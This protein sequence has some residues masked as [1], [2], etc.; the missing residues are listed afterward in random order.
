MRYDLALV[1]QLCREIGL[2]VRL[3]TDRRIEVDLGR[4][5]ILCVQ[6][7]EREEDCLIGLLG[8]PWH[9]HDNL[10]FVGGR[11][12]FIELDYLDLLTGLKEGR[13][14]IC[15]REVKGRAA[16]IW[17]VHSEFNDELKYLA[18]G[19]RIIVS[20]ATVQPT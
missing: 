9:V 20:R 4:G 18:E 10:V 15:E 7:A 2:I 14:L 19:E 5:T 12:Y 6:N 16:D 13:V 1:D 3:A 17:L 11:G 8:M